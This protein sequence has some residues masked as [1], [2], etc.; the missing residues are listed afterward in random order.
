MLYQKRKRSVYFL[1]KIGLIPAVIGIK[2]LFV[3]HYFNH[4]P[5]LQRV[6]TSHYFFRVEH[7]QNYI[8]TGEKHSVFGKNFAAS[9][10]S[11]GIGGTVV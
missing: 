4:I 3:Y 6:E 7:I 10:L 9:S 11:S 2:K 1:S 8:Y 5:I